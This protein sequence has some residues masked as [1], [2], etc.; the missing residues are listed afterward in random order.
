MKRLTVFIAIAVLV[1]GFF[2]FDLNQ[3]LTLDG[4]KSGLTQFESWRAASPLIVG[5]AFFLFYVLVAALSLPGAAIMT[6]AAGALFGLMWGTVIV[7]FASSVGATLAFLASRYVLK[8]SVQKRFADRLKPINSGIE[9]DG[10]FYLFSLRLV[11]VFPFF[12]INLLMGLT[13]IRARTFYW[14]SQVG[15]LAGTVVY[16]NAGTQLAQLESVSGILSPALLLSFAALGVFP[17]I[18]KKSA[19]CL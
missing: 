2:Y 15:M 10:A 13:P 19:G 18:A 4:L 11:P 7:S 1:I 12:L 3:L 5:A 6:L 14:V 9:K 16:V 17:L 8:D